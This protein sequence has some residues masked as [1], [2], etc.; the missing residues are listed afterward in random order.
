MENIL[1]SVSE[2]PYGVCHGDET[3]LQFQPYYIDYVAEGLNNADLSVSKTLL[4]LWK[5]FVKTG[6]ASTDGIEIFIDET[7]NDKC[8]NKFL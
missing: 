1:P 7:E 2:A 5:N 4:E 8:S 3:F 6:K